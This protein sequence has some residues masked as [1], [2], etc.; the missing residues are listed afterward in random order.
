MQN[1]SQPLRAIALAV[2]LGLAAATAP[3]LAQSGGQA[4][5]QQS[6]YKQPVVPS[7]LPSKPQQVV[8][9]LN[10]DRS[11]PF[12]GKGAKG[13]AV[14]RAQVLLDRHLF[15]P[16]Q[17]DGW[18]GRNM[19]HAIQSFQRANGLQVTGTVDAA[20]WQALARG[21]Q[22]PVFTTYALTQDDVKGPYK[23]IP[24]DPK[25]MA[26][27]ERL[28]YE[29]LREALAERFHMDPEVLTALNKGVPARAGQQI[30]VADV[31]PAVQLPKGDKRIRIS[32][33]EEMLY[34][35]GADGKLLASFPVSIGGVGD[36]LPVGAKL[37]I[38]SEV[39][40]PDFKYDPELLDG[41]SG[42]PVVVPPGP[43]SPVGLMWMGLTQPHWGIHG[44]SSPSEMARV[45]TNGCIRMTNWDVLRL[46]DHVGIGTPVQL[47]S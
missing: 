43:N 16:G 21:Q 38:N 27:M 13:P 20:T 11:T 9:Q 3:A 8:Q 32:K 36:E 12:I 7:S 28:T 42:K 26:K 5:G 47:V 19:R 10:A 25:K 40:N 15:S 22:Q 37:E 33:S 35:E 2:G 39:K 46:S 44:T 41:Y 4:Q 6:V 24:D 34:L 14:L 29:S 1:N 45:E 17:L 23:K 31:R 30:V 18:Y